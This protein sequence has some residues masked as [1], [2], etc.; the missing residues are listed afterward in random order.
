MTITIGDVVMLKS[1]GPAMTVLV[2]EY[3]NWVCQWFDHKKGEHMTDAFPETSLQLV[4]ESDGDESP[5][6]QIGFSP[7]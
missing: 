2:R 1:G 3:E 5:P 6:P 7:K 4:P